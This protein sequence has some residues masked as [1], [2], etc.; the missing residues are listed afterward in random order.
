M[1]QIAIAYVQMSFT[2]PRI[3]G[4]NER[5]FQKKTF[6]MREVSNIFVHCRFYHKIIRKNCSTKLFLYFIQGF[7][8]MHLKLNWL[9]TV[10][11]NQLSFSFWK[12]KVTQKMQL[13]MDNIFRA[14]KSFIEL[15]NVEITILILIM[16]PFKAIDYFENGRNENECIHFTL[17]VYVSVEVKAIFM[18]LKLF[19]NSN[20]KWV[21]KYDF[22]VVLS[23]NWR[24]EHKM[25]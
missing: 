16:R 24:S 7:I 4:L 23:I 17:C 9:P 13:Q 20:I 11:P 10:T 15:F 19:C 2:I 22:T 18:Y 1:P 6:E 8:W 14:M 12:I 3:A 21:Y 5:K 25:K